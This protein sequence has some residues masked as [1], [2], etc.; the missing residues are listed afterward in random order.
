M[1]EKNTKEEDD[2]VVPPKKMKLRSDKGKKL[3]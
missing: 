1:Q 2:Y 3:S